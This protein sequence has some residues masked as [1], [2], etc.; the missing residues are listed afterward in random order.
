[1]HSNSTQ[2]AR[3]FAIEIDP[4]M[5]PWLFY[6]SLDA[7]RMSTT[8]ELLATYAALHAFGFVLGDQDLT[9]ER[10]LAMVAGGTDNLATEQL[11]RKRLTTKLPLG[12]LLLQFHTKLWD[13]CLWMDL[14]W[15]PRSENVEADR[16]TN[17]D[18]TGFAEEN[19]VDFQFSQMDLRLL[20]RLQSHLKAF[21]EST[22]Q[23]DEGRLVKKGISK[24]LKMETKSK[25]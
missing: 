12:I 9:R 25:W 22:I 5:A 4:S 14:R 20:D 23:T 18:F 6:K 7:Q 3:W 1:M 10:A 2:S 16:L 19:R 24:R 15:R 11:A 8:A 17:L 13:N 21:E